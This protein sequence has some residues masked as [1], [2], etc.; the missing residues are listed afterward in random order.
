M[1]YCPYCG[2]G[3]QE[4]MAFCPSCGKRFIRASA[5][6]EETSIHPETSEISVAAITEVKSEPT[7]IDELSQKVK[8]K[9]RKSPLI[10]V[11]CIIVA[12]I[13]AFGISQ[14]GNRVKTCAD[15][16]LYLELY[17]D[18]NTVIGSASGFLIEDNTTLVTNYHVIDGTCHII[19]KTADGKECTS[20][21]T[22]L[23]YDATLDL[24]ILKCEKELGVLP[25]ALGDSAKIKQGDKVYAIGYPLGLANTL[26]NGIISSLYVNNGIETIQTTAAIS[27]GS[28]G[29]VL[30]NR[31]GEAIG[32]TTASYDNGQN[33]NLAIPINYVKS[34]LKQ[35]NPTV[36]GTS[37]VTGKPLS[38]IDDLQGVWLSTFGSYRI[39]MSIKE[40]S[41]NVSCT[42][43]D[44]SFSMAPEDNHGTLFEKDGL[45]VISWA[46]KVV[47]DSTSVV[48]EYSG[49]SLKLNCIYTNT[50]Y[51]Q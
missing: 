25:I 37:K 2:A 43:I 26:S 40:T 15:S 38:S 22:V 17:D 48:I 6:V 8:R 42:R 12:I 19:A 9:K 7:N 3:L 18:T 23:S 4:D 50:F 14:V 49:D 31:R 21:D 5:R 16:V 41:V 10:I 36:L 35:P 1:K 24:A 28:S 46:K 34:L 33:L 27:A 13:I 39:E 20:A 51:R 32:V 44:D 11:S 29:G 45:F 30:L 47:Q